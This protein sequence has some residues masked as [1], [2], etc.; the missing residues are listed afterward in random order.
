MPPPV[1]ASRERCAGVPFVDQFHQPQILFRLAGGFEIT[2]RPRNGKSSHCPS[3]VTS[4]VVFSCLSPP[5]IRRFYHLKGVSSFW[6]AL[7]TNQGSS[8]GNYVN[9]CKHQLQHKRKKKKLN[10][11]SSSH[12]KNM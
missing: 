6:G 12:E 8:E 3:A 9:W 7:Q 1:F 10:K 5:K 11:K 4:A 2:C